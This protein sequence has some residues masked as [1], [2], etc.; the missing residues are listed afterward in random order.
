M[1]ATQGH[2]R[3]PGRI[4]CY[5]STRSDLILLLRVFTLPAPHP[6]R[7][8]PRSWVPALLLGAL[9][10]TLALAGSIEPAQSE[11][12]PSPFSNNQRSA[13]SMTLTIAPARLGSSF[14]RG[15]VGLSLEA[16][17]LDTH[18]LSATHRSL[19]ALMRLLGP[20]VLRLGGYSLDDSWWTSDAEKAPAWAKSIVTPVNL[21]TL[22]QLLIATGWRAI[23]GVNLGHFDSARAA[24]EV[25]SANSILGSLLLGVEIGNEPNDYGISRVALRPSSYD[26]HDYL[27]ELAAYRAA[28]NAATPNIRIYGPDLSSSAWLEAVAANPHALF[29][30]IT[31]HF[32]PTSYSVASSVCK[33]TPVPTA[34]ELLSPQVREHEDATLLTLARAGDLAHRETRI[35][36]TN[37]TSSCDTSGGPETSPVFASALWS[38]DWALRSAS[39][40]VSGLNFHGYFGRCRPEAFSPICAPGYA[41]AARGEVIAR[42]EYYGLLAARQLEGGRFIRVQTHSPG[43]A[44]DVT[45]YATKHANGDITLAIDNLSTRHLTAF[46]RVVGFRQAVSEPLLAPSL[47]ATSGV[48][49]GH[50]SADTVGV[51]RRA[52][53]ALSK[54]AGAFV[55]RLQ[56]TSAAVITLRRS[57]P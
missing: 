4:R 54:K 10:V 33:E 27:K 17:E 20:G 46:L 3:L 21:T 43:A 24:S 22:R 13:Q 28:I 6:A 50:A 32:Y 16:D 45:S 8:A 29:A 55:L 26:V 40:G 57:M 36:E 53:N 7:R 2:V 44:S 41:E 34:L 1:S 37:N 38:L 25:H 30:A 5:W 48:T 15:T 52:G 12:G 56:P 19:V 31:Q 42:P 51:A 9:A 35:S 23:L 11:R 39:A 14:A 47:H 49:F 18:D